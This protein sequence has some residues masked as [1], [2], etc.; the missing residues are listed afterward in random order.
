MEGDQNWVVVPPDGHH[1]PLDFD[2]SSGFSPLGKSEPNGVVCLVS[3]HSPRLT[4]QKTSKNA[5]S[6]GD[7]LTNGKHQLPVLN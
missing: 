3:V 1:P 7:F 2:Q 4:P 5:K 6:E